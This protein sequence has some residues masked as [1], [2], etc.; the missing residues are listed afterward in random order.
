MITP[1]GTVVKRCR[2]KTVM[3]RP[4]AQEWALKII[5]TPPSISGLNTEKCPLIKDT[6]PMNARDSRFKARFSRP[7]T[8]YSPEGTQCPGRPPDYR[9][10]AT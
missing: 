9:R 1:E 7:A 4:E 5:A 8:A 3:S 10:P 6:S 2:H